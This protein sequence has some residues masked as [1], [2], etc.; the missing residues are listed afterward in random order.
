VL[1]KKLKQSQ[2]VLKEN[3]VVTPTNSLPTALP[4]NTLVSLHVNILSQTNKNKIKFQ[5]LPTLPAVLTKNLSVTATN[6]IPLQMHQRGKPAPM[7]T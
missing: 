7:L 2:Q 6:A 1:L 3:V 5:Q 4:S